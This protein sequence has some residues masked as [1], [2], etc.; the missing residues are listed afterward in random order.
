MVAYK[1]NGKKKTRLSTSRTIHGCTLGGATGNCKRIKI[2]K[3]KVSLKVKKTFLIKAR[4]VVSKKKKAF[5]HR[6]FAYESSNKNVAT[7]SVAGKIQAVA[8]GKCK[9]Y[10]YAQNGKY[11]T[12]Y[13]T[14]K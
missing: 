8:K 4:E 14:V 6:P 7:V 12:V 2:N 9:I 5:H 3:T 11:K 10:V 1:V 13:V